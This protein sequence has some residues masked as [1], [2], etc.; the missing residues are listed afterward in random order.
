MRYV[1]EPDAREILDKA[2]ELDERYETHYL[3]GL[4]C[5]FSFDEDGSVFSV[6]EKEDE[7]LVAHEFIAANRV[8]DIMKKMDGAKAVEFLSKTGYEPFMRINI[9]RRILK[10]NGEEFVIEKVEHLGYFTNEKELGGKKVCY[11]DLLKEKMLNDS[12]KEEEIMEQAKSILQT[13]NG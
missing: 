4:N 12:E 11:A 3:F 2:K 13:I 1:L 10:Y 6:V 7:T 8:R 9:Q 5:I